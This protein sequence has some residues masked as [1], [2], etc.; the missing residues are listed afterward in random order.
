VGRKNAARREAELG[1][2][3]SVQKESG[4][5]AHHQLERTWGKKKRDEEPDNGPWSNDRTTQPKGRG[6]KRWGRERTKKRQQGYLLSSKHRMPNWIRG[7]RNKK[8]NTPTNSSK[9]ERK[10]QKRGQPRSQKKSMEN[11]TELPEQHRRAKKRRQKK[12]VIEDA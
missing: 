7:G 11:A 8:Q 1:G 12:R 9:W 6:V 2:G 4:V 3:G 5:K 10:L